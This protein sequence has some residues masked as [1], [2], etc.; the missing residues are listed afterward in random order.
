[1]K[2]IDE[3]NEISHGKATVWTIEE[4]KTRVQETSITQKAAKEVDVITAT[5]SSRWNPPAPSST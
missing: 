3:I 2:L 4:L 1:M 5:P